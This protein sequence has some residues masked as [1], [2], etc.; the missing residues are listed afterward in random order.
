MVYIPKYKPGIMQ[1]SLIGILYTVQCKREEWGS[2]CTY[3]VGE[4]KAN[5]SHCV[6]IS[7]DVVFLIDLGFSSFKQK[8]SACLIR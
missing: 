2:C 4:Y 1:Y 3:T 7:V 6:S 8:E 5:F